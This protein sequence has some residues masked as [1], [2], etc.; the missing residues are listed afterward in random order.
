MPS[1]QAICAYF[2][3]DYPIEDELRLL[4][5]SLPQT[6]LDPCVQYFTSLA[7]RESSQT[8]AA[9]RVSSHLQNRTIWVL[10]SCRAQK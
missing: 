8:L 6:G 7:L 5:V 9:Q 10:C 3:Q 2:S 1:T 4:L